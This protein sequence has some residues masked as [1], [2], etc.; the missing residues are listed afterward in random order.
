MKPPEPP[1]KEP[2]KKPEEREE[3]KILKQYIDFLKQEKEVIK[4]ER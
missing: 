1:K 4:D 2:E 3:V